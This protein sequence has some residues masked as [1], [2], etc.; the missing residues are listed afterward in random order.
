M[1]NPVIVIG[2]NY[3]VL[4][5][6]HGFKC[7]NL[8]SISKPVLCLLGVSLAQRNL[9]C[10]NYKVAPSCTRHGHFMLQRQGAPT[11]L[12]IK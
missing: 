6:C 3:F 9:F 12:I 11:E 2:T 4:W 7:A 5:N 10:I 1:Y 8:N